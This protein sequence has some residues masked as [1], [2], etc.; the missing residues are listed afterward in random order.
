MFFSRRSHFSRHALAAAALALAAQAWAADPFTVRDIRVEGLQRVEPGTVFATLPFR[1][2]DQYTDEKASAAIR[3]LFGLGLFNDVRVDVSGEV[4]VVIVQERASISDVN[5][6]GAKEFEKDALLK[7]LRD[8]GL[9]EGRSYDKALVDR[10]E[11]EIKR[12]YVNRS[13][14]GA[15][16]VTTVTPIERNR[17]NVQFSVVEGEI[18]KIKS[19]NFVG[20][21]VFSESTLKNQMELE[22]PGWLSWYT[23]TDRY[24]RAKLNADLEAVRAYYL[25]RGYL[26]M[27]FESTQVAISPDKQSIDL[28]VNISEGVPFAVAGVKLSGDYLGKDDEFKTFVQVKPGQAYN[29]RLV[30][31]TAK[32]FTDY[33]ATFGYAFARVDPTP[34]IDREKGTVVFNFVADPGRRAYVR[35][36]LIGGNTRTRDEVIRREMRQFESSWYDGDKI[37]LSRERIERLGYFKD[38]EVGLDTQEVPNSADQVDLVVSV[39]EKATGNFTFGGSFGQTERLAL[40]VGVKQDN[41]F[42]T[43]RYLSFDVNT[44][45]SNRTFAL[46]TV[47]PYF[48]Q[49]G[50]SQA[51]DLY[52]RTT[53]PA[54]DFSGDFEY[55][56]VGSALRF[57]V[58]FSERDTV[59]FGIGLEQIRIQP[60][61]NLPASYLAYGETFGYKSLSIPLNIG[62][63]RDDRD[64]LLT[65]T[66]GRLMKL[67]A[68]LAF[69]DTR[70]GRLNAQYQEYFPINKQFTLAVNTELVYGRGFSSRPFP[71]FKLLT[72]GGIGHVRGF[73]GGTL[74]PRDVTGSFSGGSKKINANVEILTPFP[75]AGN[76]RSLRMYGFVDV[77]NVYAEREK[78]SFSDMRMSVGVGVSW[79]SPVGPLRISIANPVRKFPGDRIQKLQFQVGNTF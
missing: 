9:A 38:G 13:F 4:V 24:S 32:A 50:I 31:S 18:A 5:F 56:T 45:R 65:P 64:N 79:Q 47:D 2:G 73:E 68:D 76:D 27:K 49:D 34:E 41:I 29:S 48:T 66:R 46:S 23:K 16:V 78:I 30:E 17:V 59:Y 43:G 1:I 55:R 44:S 40:N 6:V 22:S 74:G 20:N 8:V 72:G 37:K 61:F 11:Q 14:Y 53:K 35:K 77:G 58:P 51:F 36:I 19:I 62:W 69:G 33:F 28:T 67:N 39:K 3:S 63:A 71:V 15:Q 57:G 54:T 42:G 25:Q 70:F 52:A 75:G 26:E 7:S 10:A 60:G 12:Q 21:T